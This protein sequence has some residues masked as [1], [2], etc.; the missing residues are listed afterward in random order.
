M[1]GLYLAILFGVYVL[2]AAAI[3]E[4][5]EIIDATPSTPP[6]RDAYDD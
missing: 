3:N 2:M 4:D 6:T 5:R 1:I